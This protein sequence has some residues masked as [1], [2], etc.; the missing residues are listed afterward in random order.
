VPHLFD[1][2]GRTYPH[3][4]A[5]FY[6]FG[7]LIRDAHQQRLRPLIQR[8][9]QTTREGRHEVETKALALLI[10]TY[11]EQVK[12]FQWEA[13]REVILDRLEGSRRSIKGHDL[14]V[15]IRTALVVA[16]EDVFERTLKMCSSAPSTMV[17][18]S[19]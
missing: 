16:I 3:T 5:C 13:I 2:V 4:K 15:A 19:M 7:W 14:E 10:T 8:I 1:G 11:R 6:F 9:A 12:T 18:I 17:F